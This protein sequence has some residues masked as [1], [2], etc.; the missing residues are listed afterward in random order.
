MVHFYSEITE[1]EIYKIIQINLKDFERF[2]HYINR[3][4]TNPKKY[5]MNIK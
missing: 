3:L 4:I 5:S 2:C 1:K